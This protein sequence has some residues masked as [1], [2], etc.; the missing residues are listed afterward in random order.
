MNRLEQTLTKIAQL[1]GDNGIPYMLIGGYSMAIH[2]YPRFTEDLDITLGV[3]ID[4]FDEVLRTVSKDF[5]TLVADPKEFAEKT[6]VLLLE[7][8]ATGVRVDLVFSFIDFERQAIE[9]AETII[10]NKIPIKNV[11]IENLLVYKMLAGRERDK[12]DVKTLLNAYNKAIS[13]DKV[14]EKIKQ[15][16]IILENDVYASWRAILADLDKTT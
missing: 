16:S 9:E 15:L 11:S 1:F 14:S 12:E 5:K 4:A 13:K 7:S 10:I 2:G 3:D 6:N 8:I